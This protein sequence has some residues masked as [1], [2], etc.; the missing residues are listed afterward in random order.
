[1]KQ[2]QGVHMK[3]AAHQHLIQALN[4]AIRPF[5]DD[6]IGHLLEDIGDARVVLIGE[7]SHGSH[8]FYQ[9]RIAITKQLIEK[10][11]FMAVAIEGDWPDTYPVYRYLQGKGELG[12][13]QHALDAFKR[14]PKWMWRNT[15][16]PPFLQWLRAH[17]DR[18]SGSN[19]IG[20]YGLDLY[21]LNASIQAVLG[22]LAK[23]DPEAA[24][25][26]RRRYTCFDHLKPDPQSYGYLT[27]S[28]LK[29]ACIKEVV[30]Q[31]LEIQHHALDYIKK[32]GLEGADEY[33][34]A[35]QNARVIKNAEN[36]YRTMFES[37]VSSWN[38]RDTHMFETFNMLAEHL[39]KRSNKMAKIVIWA[40][41]SH[42]GDARATEM[43]E[44][45]ELNIG[46]LIREQYGNDSYHIGF[47]T[48]EGNVTATSSW[49]QPAQ[50]KTIN[51]GITESYEDLFHQL[52]YDRFILNLRANKELE[53]YLQIPRLQRAIGV[54]YRPETERYSH[55]FF[56]RLPYQFDS[57]IHHDKTSALKPLDLTQ[58]WRQM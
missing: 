42:V 10:K 48:Y 13:S 4:K 19:K 6:Q 51:P 34:Y 38:I 16:I 12:D 21:S 33:F 7:A 39:E 3:Q 29:K 52:Q 30:A 56:T 35:L 47:S 8:E 32:D 58:D 2:A 31:L 24:E 20:F 15:T 17:N 41:N 26:A 49:D 14:Y 44:R 46:Q 37:D 50:C 54:I 5:S 23:V 55:Y 18:L 27:S 45:N 53:H 43:G 40:H 9:S 22:Y 1:M 11:G 25:K 57:I 36:Y 28:G